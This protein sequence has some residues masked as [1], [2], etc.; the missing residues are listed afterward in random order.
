MPRDVRDTIEALAL[1][2]LRSP[3]VQAQFAGSALP[4]RRR[5]ELQILL[6]AEFKKWPLLIPKLGIKME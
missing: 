4:T 5:A 6:D 2:V 1:A 3:D